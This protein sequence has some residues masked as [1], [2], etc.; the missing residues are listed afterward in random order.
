MHLFAVVGWKI[1]NKFSICVCI[2]WKRNALYLA[3]DRFVRN[4]A[5][6]SGALA[7]SAR[8]R[9]Q[10]KIILKKGSDIK[11]VADD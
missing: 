10:R 2:F 4:L 11:M 7:E 8:D 9:F 1:H 6:F 3:T 5:R